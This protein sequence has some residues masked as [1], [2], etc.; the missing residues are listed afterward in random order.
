MDLKE[1]KNLNMSELTA[2]EQSLK[3]ELFVMRQQSQLGQ[4]EKPA[5]FGILRK[6]VAQILTL[7]NERKKINGKSN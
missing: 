6:Q 5:R 3:K 1:L 2:L 4:A 7:L